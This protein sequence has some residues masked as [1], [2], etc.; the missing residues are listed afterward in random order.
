MRLRERPCLT[1]STACLSDLP[2]LFHVLWNCSI[3]PFSVYVRAQGN[4]NAAS[5]SRGVLN[6]LGGRLHG[7]SKR[8]P[9]GHAS[10]DG[11]WRGR[12]TNGLAE[13]CGIHRAVTL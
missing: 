13:D 7:S 4:R 3:L 6:P 2:R 10:F 8:H 1:Y 5:I 11:N 12:T 9:S